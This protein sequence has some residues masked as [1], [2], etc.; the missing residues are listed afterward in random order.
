MKVFF[1]SLRENVTLDFGIWKII[2]LISIVSLTRILLL[3]WGA[4]IDIVLRFKISALLR[5]NMLSCILKRPGAESLKLSHG[6]IVNR[7]RDD[8]IQVEN[9]ISW[10]L[11]VIGSCVFALIAFAILI[12][13]KRKL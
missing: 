2:I 8:A 12:S 1:D 11:D 3:F 7:F 10:T 5:K 13:I 6:E 4:P 9:S